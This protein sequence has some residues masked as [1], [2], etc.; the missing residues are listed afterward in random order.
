MVLLSTCFCSIR[1]FH[2]SYH[3]VSKQKGR[4]G[5]GRLIP[6]MTFFNSILVPNIDKP[7]KVT[8]LCTKFL[9]KEGNKDNVLSLYMP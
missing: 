9:E 1:S 4:S 5:M 2:S 6:F 7:S 8:I 3:F